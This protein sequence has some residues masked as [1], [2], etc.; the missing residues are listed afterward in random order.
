MARALR[1]WGKKRGDRRT[2]SKLLGGLGEVLFFAVLFLL[3]A[4]SLTAVITKHIIEPQ[5]E[6][7]VL[8]SGYGFWL[9]VLVLASFILI[10]GAGFILSVLHVGTS[11]ERRSAL[12]KRA[13]DIELIG[14][15][16]LESKEYPNVPEDE[17][18]TNSPGIVLSY[19]LP[20][21]QTQVWS[22][23]AATVFCLLWNGIAIALLV[24]VAN[25]IMAGQPSWFLTA[26][27]LPVLAI[28]VWSIYYFAKQIL[29]QSGVGPTSV[30]VSDHPLR[31]GRKYEVF[32]SQAGQ[33]RLDSL[34]IALVCEE[35]ATYHQGTDIRTERKNVY[36]RPVFRK[37]HFQIEP[38]MPFEQQCEIEL[39]RGVMHSFHGNHNAVHWKLVVHGDGTSWQSFNR[40]F[41]VVVFPAAN[42]KEDDV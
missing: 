13:K 26:F 16:I 33:L 5:P 12:A 8:G 38:G 24:V 15:A 36:R 30:E 2:G 10:G 28:G 25:G 20:A 22:L 27:L 1:L 17:N 4:A 6:A 3:G 34:E 37:E 32:L 11:A 7:Y 39:P 9:M 29:A 14:E 41:P 35:E 21:T 40:S 23:T 19:R 42:G 31:P 18:L